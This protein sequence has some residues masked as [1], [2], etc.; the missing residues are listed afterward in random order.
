MLLL[1]KNPKSVNFVSLS[2][3]IREIGQV[4][5]VFIEPCSI[6]GIQYLKLLFISLGSPL[7]ALERDI[8]ELT[9]NC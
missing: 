3:R 9:K 5:T 8:F 7:G 4:I 2:N 6:K 1:A